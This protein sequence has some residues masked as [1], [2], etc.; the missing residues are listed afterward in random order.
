MLPVLAHVARILARDSKIPPYQSCS[1][2]FYSCGSECF[3]SVGPLQALGL[4]PHLEQPTADGLFSIDI[5]LWPGDAARRV[6]I[7]VDGMQKF[8]ANPPWRVLGPTA[9]RCATSRQNSYGFP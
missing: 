5:A 1:N 4:E 2:Y 3:A 7:E 6:A 9:F 8:S